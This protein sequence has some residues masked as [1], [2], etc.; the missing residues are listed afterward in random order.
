MN[1]DLKDHILARLDKVWTETED[2]F[3]DDFFEKQTVVI[4]AL[5]NVDVR[6]YIYIYTVDKSNTRILLIDGGT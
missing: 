6:R 3:S 2:I 1:P 5:G 4:N